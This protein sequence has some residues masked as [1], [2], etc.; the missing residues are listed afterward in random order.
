MSKKAIFVRLTAKPGM[1]H[2][3]KTFL[4]SALPLAEKE[5]QTKTWFAIQFDASTFGIF[6]SFDDDAGRQAHLNGAIASALMGAADKLL[7][8]PPNIELVDVLAS[9]VTA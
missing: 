6:D 3:L 2:E 8:S 9:K 1:E 5:A 7:S 4:E